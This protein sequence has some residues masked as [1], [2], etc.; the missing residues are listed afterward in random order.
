MVYN[1]AGSLSS[2]YHHEV[3]PEFNL[4]AVQVRFTTN[5]LEAREDLSSCTS[6]TIKRIFTT[7]MLQGFK[8]KQ[9]LVM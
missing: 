5:N 2:L 8:R 3:G 7:P 9:V 6:G 4:K 1:G